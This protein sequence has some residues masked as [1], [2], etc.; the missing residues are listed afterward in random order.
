MEKDAQ[1]S[2][3]KGLTLASVTVDED[4]KWIRFETAD[5]RSF[6]MEHDQDC[7]ESVYVED[8]VGDLA[9]LIAHPIEIALE[10]SH[11]DGEPDC[12]KPPGDDAM[13]KDGYADHESYRWTFYKLATIKG[14]VDIR[15]FGSSNGYYSEAVSFREVVAVA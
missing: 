11:A 8:I 6:V 1:F 13:E 4:K 14:Y 10:V 9:D 3:L 15:W 7:C 5:G 12:P 2:D